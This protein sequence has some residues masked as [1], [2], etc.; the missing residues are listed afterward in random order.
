MR[1]GIVI[2]AS[3]ALAA[4]CK[5]KD[6]GD[7]AAT[8]AGG[9][10]AAGSSSGSSSAAAGKSGGL[11]TVAVRFGGK[12]VQMQHAFVK[13]MD[14]DR[15]QIYLT[16]TGGSCDELISN[17]FESG[18]VDVLA[19]VTPR[20]NADGKTYLQVT[21]VFEG[22]PTMVIDPG[23]RAA[24]NGDAV[25]GE[26]VEVSL[27][28]VARAQE[29]KSLVVEVH[30]SFTAQ[31]CGSRERDPS[32]VPRAS[33]PTTATLTIANRRLELK[34]AIL[35]GTGKDPDLLL[36]TGVKDCSASTPW[37]YVVL[38]RSGGRWKAHGTWLEKE[39]IAAQRAD[40]QS[41]K[42]TVGDAR[43]MTAD[44]PTAQLSLSGAGKLG[45]YPIA[46]DGTIEAIDCAGK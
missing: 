28:F 15:F 23:A 44:G 39:V 11:S 4:A 33:H 12:P 20:L 30:G 45:G 41:F 16:E 3:L 2:A 26:P 36:T 24:I 29:E 19:N 42:V 10:S 37:A 21:D 13:R 38:E 6:K 8:K 1:I 31:G 40:D 32:G 25:K 43:G 9:G 14:P 27:D 5:G 22:A 18:R 7:E 17:L 34:G 46:I 35:N